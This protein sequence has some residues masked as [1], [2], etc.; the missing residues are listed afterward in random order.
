[1]QHITPP[2]TDRLAYV[3][4]PYQEPLA[5]V[6]PGETFQISTLD[7]FGNRIDSTDIDYMEPSDPSDC[8][9]AS[10]LHS[11]LI[12][13]GECRSMTSSQCGTGSQCPAASST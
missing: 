7:A 2:Q 5:T 3:I 6:V 11:N 10:V 1:M 8:S 12:G 9:L 4:C 13:Y